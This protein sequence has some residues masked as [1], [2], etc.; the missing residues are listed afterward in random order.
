MK[1]G[2]RTKSVISRHAHLAVALGLEVSSAVHLESEVLNAGTVMGKTATGKYR[3]YAQAEV[4]VAFDAA[5]PNFTLDPQGEL[6]KHLRE[7]D[8]ITKLDGTALGVIAT[9]NKETG[10]GTLEANSAAAHAIGEEVKI[11]E[12]ECSIEDGNGRVLA[13]FLEADL[14]RLNAVGYV[15]GYVTKDALITDHAVSKFG[16]KL[17]E[18]EFR[19]RL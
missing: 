1:Q 11:D 19:M 12:D 7:G 4:S 16:V 2:L 8:T 18:D 17:S 6:F 5:N 15:E 9:L 14:P 13:N 3:A 10:V